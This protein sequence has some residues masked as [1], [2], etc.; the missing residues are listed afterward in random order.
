MGGFS[1]WHWVIFLLVVVLVFGTKK[2]KN[3][4]PD[5][6]NAIKGFKDAMAEPE[7]E[8]EKEAQQLANEQHKDGTT[9][10]VKAEKVDEKP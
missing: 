9:V 4:G 6:G 1:L 2:L 3:L 7:K 10:D 5:L 8:K